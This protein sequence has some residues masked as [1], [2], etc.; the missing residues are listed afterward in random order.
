MIVVID[1]YDSFVHNLA[2][3]LRRAGPTPV[4]V[5][6][7][8][9]VTV[10]ELEH[11]APA[12]LII[13]PGPCGPD[14]AGISLA[15]VRAA[16][17]RI[18]VLGVC[19]GHQVIVQNAGGSIVRGEPIHGMASPV[20]HDDHPLFEGIPTPFQAGRYHS[21]IA[22]AE[23]LPE[24]LEPI[25]WTTDRTIMAV[26]HRQH[27]VIGVQFHPESILTEFGGRLIHNF[28]RLSGLPVSRERLPRAE[29]SNSVGAEMAQ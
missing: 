6:R 12:A 21:L 20:H 22:Q 17:G 24:S 11:I 18:P 16:I 4:H 3:Y 25:A 27:P 19:L 9:Q 28:L 1:N 29:V 15:A 8:D 26:A 14:Q 23:T 5:V 2:R 7:N 13:S 10:R